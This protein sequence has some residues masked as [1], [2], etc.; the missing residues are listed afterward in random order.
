[1]SKTTNTTTWTCSIS[2]NSLASKIQLEYISKLVLSAVCT[3]IIKR[4]IS[5]YAGKCPCVRHRH[6]PSLRM[7]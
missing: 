5:H 2:Y 3:K 7:L 6:H 1:M 4:K